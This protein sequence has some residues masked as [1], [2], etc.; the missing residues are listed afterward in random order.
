MEST[1]KPNNVTAVTVDLVGRT[2][3]SG[4]EIPLDNGKLRVTEGRKA[5]GPENQDSRVTE[6]GNT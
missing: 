6:G 1:R 3:L 2:R 5:T 4:N